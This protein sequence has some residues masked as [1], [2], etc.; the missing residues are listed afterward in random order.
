VVHTLFARV[1]TNRDGR[2]T[3]LELSQE[4]QRDAFLG[5]VLQEVGLPTISRPGKGTAHMLAARQAT[6][7]AAAAE[8]KEAT[9]ATR[10]LEV[11]A[12]HARQATKMA[13]IGLLLVQQENHNQCVAQ[14]GRSPMGSSH[15]GPTPWSP[16]SPSQPLDPDAFVRELS[17][18]DIRELAAH[19]SF[20]LPETQ[21]EA[22]RQVLRTHQAMVLAS[23]EAARAAAAE[24]LEAEAQLRA[25]VIW[26]AAGVTE[27]GG[28][29]EELPPP[30]D[31]D[32]DEDEVGEL[33]AA[34]SFLTRTARV[35][36]HGGHG[37]AFDEFRDLLQLPLAWIGINP[38]VA[39]EKELL[40]MIGNLA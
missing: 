7:Q 26:A 4:I 18:L 14:A 13:I 31:E 12:A 21:T 27:V 20:R 25:T 40:N 8:A 2:L 33:I 6:V 11:A 22:L 38:I 32:E 29:D 30:D 3:R 34:A 24:E 17:Q 36:A 19:A 28:S 1:D 5:R 9:A 23:E 15:G 10:Q 37:I 39:L 16:H 35:A